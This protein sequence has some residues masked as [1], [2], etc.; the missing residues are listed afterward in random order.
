MAR[1]CGKANVLGKAVEYIRV[2]KKRE[3]RLKREQD[4]LKALVSGP[5][6]G[7]ALL[8]TWE[9]EWKEKFGGEEKD[10]VDAL[11]IDL[12]ESL[13]EDNGEEE[14]RSPKVEVPSPPPTSSVS[15]GPPPE[16]RKREDLTPLSANT[17]HRFKL[18]SF[19]CQL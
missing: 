13:H 15:A 17:N 5:V 18:S 10:G 12:P 2:L 4:G 9:N 1:K 16:K 19:S 7:S 14:G 3:M 8:R 11:D 6:G